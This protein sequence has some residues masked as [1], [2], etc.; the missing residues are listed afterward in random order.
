[1]LRRHPTRRHPARPP[2]RRIRLATRLRWWRHR[3]PGRWWVAVS[4][5]ALGSAVAADAR[6]DRPEQACPD[7]ASTTTVVADGPGVPAAERLPAGTRGVAVP[8]PAGLALATGDRVDVLA[9]AAAEV[10]G[11]DPAAPTPTAEVVARAAPVVAVDEAAV[12]VA[13]A[14]DE[15][16]VVAEAATRAAATLV[17]TAP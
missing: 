10:E 5:L 4:V 7:P 15:V 14:A 17:L 9:T 8:A 13:V 12:T 11:S 6:L 2:T 3:H 16:A 1:M